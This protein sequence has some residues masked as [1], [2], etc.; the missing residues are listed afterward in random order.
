[1]KFLRAFTN[2]A[3]NRMIK[4]EALDIAWEWTRSYREENKVLKEQSE[5]VQKEFEE[6]QLKHGQLGMKYGKLL[7]E[8]EKRDESGSSKN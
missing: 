5:K 3:V 2:S 8:K 7:N 4:Q 6:L 1:M